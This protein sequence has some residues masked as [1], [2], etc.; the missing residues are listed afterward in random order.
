MSLP[1]VIATAAVTAKNTLKPTNLAPMSGERPIGVPRAEIAEPRVGII[2]VMSN[3]PRILPA[4]EQVDPQASERLLPRI[5][6]EKVDDWNGRG[7][8]LMAAAEAM[9]R[10][11]DHSS[12]AQQPGAE[13]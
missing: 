11:H 2:G 3:D 4:F 5:D 8:L 9:R 10:I 12:P 1:E 7:H 6:A 13:L